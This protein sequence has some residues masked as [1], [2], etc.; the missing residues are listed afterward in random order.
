MGTTPMKKNT[1]NLHVVGHVG[2]RYYPAYGKGR[3][4]IAKLLIC[5]QKSHCLTQP[6]KCNIGQNREGL[7]KIANKEDIQEI[8]LV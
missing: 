2:Y 4:M 7:P 5:S 8:P 3:D 1:C 6:Y